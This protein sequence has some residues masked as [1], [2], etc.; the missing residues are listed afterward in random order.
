MSHTRLV[1]VDWGTSSLRGALLEPDGRDKDRFAAIRR[2]ENTGRP[3]AAEDFVR[4]LER[5]SSAD[6]RQIKPDDD[7]GE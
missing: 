7:S 4:D 6:G 3:L 1:A 2:A 5:N